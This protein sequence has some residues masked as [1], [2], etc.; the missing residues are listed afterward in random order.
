VI[1][2]LSFA[3][4]HIIGTLFIMYIILFHHSCVCKSMLE[5]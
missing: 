3:I 1:D 4:F 5:N 2:V